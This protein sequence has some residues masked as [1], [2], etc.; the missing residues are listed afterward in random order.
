MAR[1]DETDGKYRVCRVGHLDEGDEEEKVGTFHD[2]LRYSEDGLRGW[3]GNANK[4]KKSPLESGEM[5]ADCVR[6]VTVVS[7]LRLM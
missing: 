4:T 2:V 1:R 6:D 3:R 5:R 7:L